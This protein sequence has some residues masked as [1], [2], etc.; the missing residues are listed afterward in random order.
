MNKNPKTEGENDK[1]KEEVNK[2]GNKVRNKMLKINK[3]NEQKIE[4]RNK[5]STKDGERKGQNKAGD[6]SE[7]G[8]TNVF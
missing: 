8:D 6:V 1:S 7:G 2:N 4:R 5:I 3:L